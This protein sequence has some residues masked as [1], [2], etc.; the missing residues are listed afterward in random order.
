MIDLSNIFIAS[1]TAFNEDFKKGESTTKMGQ[2]ARHIFLNS[3][4]SY[5][6]MWGGKCGN[7]IICCDGKHNWRKDVFPP[8]KG[9]RKANREASDTDWLSIFSI[10]NEIKIELASIF[11]YKVI[12]A[13]K[14]EG[15]DVIFT[16]SDYFAENEFVVYGLEES[17]Q[18]VMNIS[19]DHDFLQQY[20]HKN[21]AQWSPRI[22]KV[23]P[24]PPKTFL[25]EK[26][27]T[28]DEGDGIPSVL[29]TDDF[30]MDKSKYG[31]ALP[32]TKKVIEKYSNLSNLNEFELARYKRNEQLI[33]SEYVP[34][35]IRDRIIR[36]YKMAPDKADRQAIFEY[37]IKY[38]LRQHTPRVA[39]F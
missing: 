10:L 31:R 36:L 7:I 20:K 24:R 28:G 21:Y 13:D 27:I 26:I 1:V 38:N 2:I 30:C 4:L 9:V 39:E 22:K 11:P 14:A 5:K 15:D 33:S 37:C 6:K 17:P 23:I 8:Y 19:S 32:I 34:H 35:D 12:Q 25:I 3:I 16:L 18:H 29:M